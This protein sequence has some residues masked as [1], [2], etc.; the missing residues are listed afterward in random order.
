MFNRLK[1]AARYLFTGRLTPSQGEII[2]WESE[3]LT[4]EQLEE[5]HR[6]AKRRKI[7]E[8]LMRE[9]KTC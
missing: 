4:A 5:M 9:G 3:W 8:W 7:I 6:E 1:T 2:E